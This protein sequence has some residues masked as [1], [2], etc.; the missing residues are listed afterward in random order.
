LSFFNSARQHDD[1]QPGISGHVGQRK[2][3]VEGLLSLLQG[4]RLAFD[5]AL[6]GGDM[7]LVNGHALRG[8]TQLPAP[9]DG[10]AESGEA[11]RGSSS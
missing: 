7:N 4:R 9:A 1:A 10:E 6:F 3:D 2:A 8:V 5:I 11:E